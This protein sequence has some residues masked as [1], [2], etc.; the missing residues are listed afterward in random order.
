[1]FQHPIVLRFL[2]LCHQQWQSLQD[3]GLGLG[4]GLLSPTQLQALPKQLAA[5]WPQLQTLPKQLAANPTSPQSL[6][7]LALPPLAWFILQDIWQLLWCLIAI[8][9]KIS[10]VVLLINV[11]GSVVNRPSSAQP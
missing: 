1:M 3:L 10:G 5:L 6:A 7:A 9:L 8:G 2:Q 4:L 11:V